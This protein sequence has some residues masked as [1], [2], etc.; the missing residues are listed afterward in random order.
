LLDL[1]SQ[2]GYT[3]AYIHHMHKI[4]RDDGA[5]MTQEASKDFF[6]SY[7][8]ADR[9]WAEW[10]A[11]QLEAEGYTTVLQAWDFL[12][13]S[14]FVVDMN[15]A[16][17]QASRTVAILSPDYF[18]S[19]FTQPEWAAAFA[20]DP[21]GEQG[22]LV[23]VRVRACT[24]PRILA[25]LVYIDLV[26]LD[27]RS[28]IAAVRAGLT[29]TR[30]RPPTAPHFPGASAAATPYA[31]PFPGPRVLPRAWN[32]PFR[33]NP[34]FTG[35]EVVLTELHKLLDAGTTAALS[36]PSAISGLGGIGKTQT[37]VE[38]AYR[39]LDDYQFVLWVQAN[40]QETLLADF[41]SL[42]KQLDLPEQ[43]EPEQQVVVHAV[44]QWLES[45]RRWLLIFDN[46]DDLAMVQDYL[47][48]GNQGHVLFTTRAQAMSGLAHKVE[49]KTM[50]KEEEEEG[51]LFL[52][53][54][55]GLLAPGATLERISPAYRAL[56]RDIVQEMGGLPLALDQAGAYLEET[57]ESLSNYLQIYQ[58][59]RAALLKR[60]GGLKPPHPE[61]V[62]TTWSLALQQV[63]RAQPAAIELMRMC[64]LLAPDA[65]PEELIVEGAASLGPVLQPV[66]TDRTR[67]NEVLAALL[68]YSLLR[69]DS[70]TQTLSIH[71]LVQAV[72]LDEL[73]EKTQ[74]LWAERVVQ[75]V[76]QVFPWDEP[77]PW[78]QSQRYLAHALVCQA[79]IQRWNL[80]LHAAVILLDSASLYLRNRGQYQAAEPLLQEALALGE[81]KDGIDHP[82]TSNLLN[83]LA[84]LYWNQ[85]K[86]EEVEPLLQRVLAINEKMQ[87]LEH[88][89]TV[90]TLNNLAV[91][92]ADQGKYEEAEKL[93]QRAL[94]IVEKTVGP[95]HPDTKNTRD[96]YTALLEK[97]KQSTTSDTISDTISDT[98]SNTPTTTP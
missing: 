14:N 28:A 65:I 69:R 98:T 97:M 40:A 96:N 11:W 61:S 93:Y 24:L 58:Q 36:Q 70:M 25:Q 44:M 23:P 53:R 4:E 76:S 91:L 71:R 52:L 92:Y 94:T 7:N 72:I 49:L 48:Q 51:V 42:A 59:G 89:T 15:L 87:G 38:Y 35:R 29:P 90:S 39:Y 67:L 81:K 21:T 50:E 13:G 73:D 32:V 88:P 84:V 8:K 27:E 12:P 33:R 34:F 56:A 3:L 64:A 43:N 83:N 1:Y 66:A 41:V 47:P 63:E 77:A 30:L 45:H 55:A 85:G 17:E 60:R 22:K 74:H 78:P 57:G 54:R 18:E 2:L 68:R 31:S 82:D 95:E 16:A 26:D 79:L 9:A 86:Y 80:T 62:A 19:K 75:A 37:A 10:I 20:E 6:I 5:A 46:A